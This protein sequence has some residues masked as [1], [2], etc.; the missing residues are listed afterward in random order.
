MRMRPTSTA[1][2]LLV[3]AL[4][5]VT[6]LSRADEQP[7]DKLTPAEARAI[8]Q[9]AY[10]FGLPLIYIAVNQDVLANV[11]KPEG[12]RAPLNQ[13]AH[14]REFPGPSNRTVVAWNV[15][16]LYSI[17]TLDLTT[18]PL[19]LSVPEMGERWWLMQI[20]DAWNDVPAA[21]GTRTVGGKGITARGEIIPYP[22][23]GTDPV[24]L[25]PLRQTSITLP[26]SSSAM[27]KRSSPW[28][29]CSDR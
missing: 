19:V 17:G 3:A 9:E 6:M 12:G 7:S 4:L 24:F 25:W 15:D 5:G 20:V 14:F 1:A 11:A 23:V 13:F 26:F 21:P 22:P 28:M 29:R 27:W 16:T 10:V 18:E 2:A 8:A